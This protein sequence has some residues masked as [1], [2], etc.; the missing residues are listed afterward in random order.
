MEIVSYQRGVGKCVLRLRRTA[1]RPNTGA[2]DGVWAEFEVA[3]Y[4]LQARRQVLY[5]RSELERFIRDVVR[6]NTD[7]TG[8]AILYTAR[9]D[10]SGLPT[11]FPLW[12]DAR[13]QREAP[14]D[15]TLRIFALGLARHVALEAR[16]VQHHDLQSGP[17]DDSL[18]VTFE[19]DPSALT[20]YAT[21]LES[22]LAPFR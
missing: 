6:F 7:R 16:V 3:C 21:E 10:L 5:A 4:G 19:L 15:A 1:S 12:W 8:E 2:G 11:A 18:V 13:R 9:P 22:E 14:P 17:V 20:R